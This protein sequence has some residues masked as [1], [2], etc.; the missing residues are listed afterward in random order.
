MLETPN[1]SLDATQ[2]GRSWDGQIYVATLQ[3]LRAFGIK[4]SQI[5]PN[6][7]VLSARPGLSGVSGMTFT[8]GSGNWNGF[9]NPGSGP[10]ATSRCSAATD[11]LANPVIQE[12]GALPTGTRH[13]TR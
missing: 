12:V 9:S 13:R 5:N 6:A 11:C 4:A 8:Y 2:D 3:T 7:D 1:A 10:P